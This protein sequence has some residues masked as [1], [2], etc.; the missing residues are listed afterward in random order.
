M[1]VC[2]CRAR[3]RLCIVDVTESFFLIAFFPPLT[4]GDWVTR[5]ERR[6]RGRSLLTILNVVVL[7]GL[8]FLVDCVFISYI[9]IVT[10]GLCVYYMRR[11][12]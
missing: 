3:T 1:N 10:V 6:R 12:R 9:C 8:F 2:S 5:A 7:T 4:M 11:R